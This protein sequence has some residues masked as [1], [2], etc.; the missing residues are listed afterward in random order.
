MLFGIEKSVEVV[1][2][3]IIAL[4]RPRSQSLSGLVADGAGFLRRPCELVDVAFDTGFVTGEF[5]PEPAVAVRGLYDRLYSVAAVVAGIAFQH[6]GVIGAGHADCSPVRP[7]CELFVIDG[8][9]RDRILLFLSRDRWK[10]CSDRDRAAKRQQQGEF[11]LFSPHI[12]LKEFLSL[13]TFQ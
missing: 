13:I 10:Q 8:L 4:R 1:S 3:R 9:L 11:Y 2:R 12:L 7:V 6:T 5:E